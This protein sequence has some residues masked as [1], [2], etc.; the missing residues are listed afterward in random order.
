MK[1]ANIETKGVENQMTVSR[2]VRNRKDT[3]NR[4]LHAYYRSRTEEEG[5]SRIC[6]Q[7][8]LPSDL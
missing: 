1:K 5:Q 4:W 3:V 2:W 6:P 7:K 8:I